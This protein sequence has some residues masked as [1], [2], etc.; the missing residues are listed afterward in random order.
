MA[1]V[2]ADPQVEPL[3]PSKEPP[4]KTHSKN[5]SST[6]VF[7]E[8]KKGRFVSIKEMRKRHVDS[9]GLQRFSAES[10]NL[11]LLQKETLKPYFEQ[12]RFN[13]ESYETNIALLKKEG[14]YGMK[15]MLTMRDLADF[16]IELQ[17]K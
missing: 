11:L 7:S 16:M 5:V 13:S 4:S 14:E 1:V 8:D 17:E 2:D 3:E 6:T 9:A 12:K 15:Q 10:K